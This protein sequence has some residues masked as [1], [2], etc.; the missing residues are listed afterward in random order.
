MKSTKIHHSYC[1]F[2][3]VGRKVTHMKHNAYT[4]SLGEASRGLG[5]KGGGGL[6]WPGQSSPVW[7]SIFNSKVSRAFSSP[8]HMFTYLYTAYSLCMPRAW[9]TRTT[10]VFGMASVHAVAMYSNL[11]CALYT[12]DHCL[13]SLCMI[14]FILIVLCL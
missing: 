13:V 4:H 11:S 14:I 5:I 12:C 9:S 1:L 2:V 10:W 8:S 7:H 6:T 3:E